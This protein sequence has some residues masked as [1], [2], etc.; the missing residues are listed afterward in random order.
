MKLKELR[1][2]LEQYCREWEEESYQLCSGLKADGEDHVVKIRTRYEHLFSEERTRW[3]S[4]IERAARSVNEVE[5][6]RRIRGFLIDRFLEKNIEQ[7]LAEISAVE[8]EASFVAEGREILYYYCDLAQAEEPAR[9]RRRSIELFRQRVIRE[10]NSKHLEL[11]SLLHTGAASLGYP[12]YLSLYEDTKQVDFA[13]LAT[14]AHQVL[15]DTTDLYQRSIDRM[16]RK[17]LGISW[18]NVRVFDLP[19]LLRGYQLDDAF[20][21]NLLVDAL[22]A[23]CEQLGLDLDKTHIEIDL[24]KREG[25]LP[26]SFCIPV[27]IPERIILVILPSS[28]YK[29][30][31][32]AFHEL[33]H[34]QH[35]TH[36]PADEP[37]E[38]KRIGDGAIK[39]TFAFLFEHLIRDARWLHTYL[40]TELEPTFQEYLFS[41]ELLSLRRNAG[42]FLYELALHQ[43][44]DIEAKQED[45]EKILSAAFCLPIY[46]EDYLV[47][48]DLGFYSGDYLRGWILEAQ[49]RHLLSER[50]GQEWFTQ[51]QAGAFLRELWR[52]SQRHSVEQLAD[53]VG[54]DLSRTDRLVMDFELALG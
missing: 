43:G 45:Y 11:F 50:F 27:Q 48:V 47:Y 51:K 35:F 9:E 42:M 19:Y 37:F 53:L 14:V 28:G 33:G 46:R 1:E 4:E 23:T 18:E 36:I 49:L 6:A 7:V 26:R 16:A 29:D 20:P 10:L 22:K 39:E 3:L 15:E 32:D 44:S 54:L 5:S 41:V 21:A 25:K 38:F 13:Q 31:V 40:G 2:S 24:E 17:F 34:A 52:V 8:E 12:S 30:Y